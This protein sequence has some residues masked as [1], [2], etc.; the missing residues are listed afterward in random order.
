M[1]HSNASEGCNS[2]LKVILQ[3]IVVNNF[4]TEAKSI[5]VEAQ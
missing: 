1:V 2:L 4:K 5:T 3:K